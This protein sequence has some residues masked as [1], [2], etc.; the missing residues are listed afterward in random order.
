[1][2]E[3]AGF[4]QQKISFQAGFK[5]Y[6]LFSIP[7]LYFLAEYNQVRPYTYA[8][9]IAAQNY[10]HYNQPLA[11]PLAANFREGLSILRYK[12][13]DWF[14][15]LKYNYAIIG[16]DH[17]NS[18][19]GSNIFISDHE[20]EKGLMSFDNYVG[21]GLETAIQ[22]RKVELAYLINPQTNL[23][24]CAGFHQRTIKNNQVNQSSPL[25]YFKFITNLKNRYFDF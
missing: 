16:K 13:K 15:S 14:F 6:N 4:F 18:H 3:G 23:Q 8:H 19:W 22:N 11:H 24:V 10:A 9:K 21:Q 17:E 5:F 1:M 2:K 12:Y 25:F 20:A 7:N